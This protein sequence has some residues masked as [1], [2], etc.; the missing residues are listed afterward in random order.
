MTVSLTQEEFLNRFKDRSQPLVLALNGDIDQYRVKLKE[1]IRVQQGLEDEEILLDTGN[2]E[3]ELIKK[4]IARLIS[5]V[6]S[7]D[8]ETS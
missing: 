4:A 7:D 1:L 3:N 5:L 8:A 2:L 6:Y